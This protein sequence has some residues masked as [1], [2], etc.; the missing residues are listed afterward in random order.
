[1]SVLTFLVSICDILLDTE[2]G[3]EGGEDERGRGGEGERERVWEE[4]ERERKERKRER[5]REERR[6]YLLGI[7]LLYPDAKLT[8]YNSIGTRMLCGCSST[9]KGTISWQN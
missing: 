4:R 8:L 2:E 6:E 7:K 1:M 9:Q 5:E 3:K